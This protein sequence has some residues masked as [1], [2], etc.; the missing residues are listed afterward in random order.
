MCEKL[1]DEVFFKTLFCLFLISSLKGENT[2]SFTATQP[3]TQ[4]K[5][6]N[7]G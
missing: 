6:G 1:Q 3:K 7:W 2:E 4:K 5:K